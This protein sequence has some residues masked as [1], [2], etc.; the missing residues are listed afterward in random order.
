MSNFGFQRMRVV[1]PYFLAFR[2]ARSAVGASAVMENAEE[3]EQIADAV[4][5]CALVVGTTSAHNRELHHPLRL[6]K[7]G[8]PI[9]RREL[10][11]QRVALLFGSEKVGLSNEALSHCNWLLQIPTREQHPAMNLGQAVAVCLYELARD[12]QSSE[13]SA[14]ASHAS[15]AELERIDDLLRKALE[16][17]G[18]LKSVSTSS[19]EVKLRR[20]IRRL[21][22]RPDDAEVL[23]AMLRQIVWKLRSFEPNTEPRRRL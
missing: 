19:G 9:L 15:A 3:F 7:R 18:Y 4:A 8:A 13:K 10:G 1:R 21:D 5:D 17:S 14:K 2:E 20:F 11:S 12:G 6:L 23:L 16:A 22:L